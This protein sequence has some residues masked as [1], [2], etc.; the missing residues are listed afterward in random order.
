MGEALYLLEQAERCRR[1]AVS[2][3]DPLAALALMKLAEDFVRRAE[4][5]TNEPRPSLP[6]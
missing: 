5:L 1:L 4:E 3:N 2:L 6:A